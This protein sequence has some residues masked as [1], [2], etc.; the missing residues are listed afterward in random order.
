M[1]LKQLASATVAMT[2]VLAFSAQS[3]AQ[4]PPPLTGPVIPG[5]CV[6]NQERAV[7]TSAAGKVLIQRL[8]EINAQVTSE[9]QPEAVQLQADQK[10]LQAQRATLTQAQFQTRDSAFE[11][12]VQAFQRKSQL[13]DAQLQLT[14]GKAE[15]Q[16]QITEVPIAREVF[17]QRS[18]SVLINSQALLGF[19]PG[20]DI[21]DAVIA[22]T[23]SK[24]P[25]VTVEL[26]TE[27]EALQAIQ[28]QQQQQGR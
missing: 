23:N 19:V 10:T 1:K 27:Q 6:Y 17:L 25:S 5:I 11:T 7:A 14:K 8:T 15:R 3:S 24:L 16:I 22:G 9:L 18:C 21:T 26:V 20:A 4:T 12:R 13:R 2:T 28:Q